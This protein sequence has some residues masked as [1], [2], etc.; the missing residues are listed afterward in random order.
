[1]FQE[2]NPIPTAPIL[3]GVYENVREKKEKEKKRAKFGSE[4]ERGKKKKK[5]K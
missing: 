1:M 4:R 5:I 2:S 3:A